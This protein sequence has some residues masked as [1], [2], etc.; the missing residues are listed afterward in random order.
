M[1]KETI[2]ITY[3]VYR[4]IAELPREEQEI[5]NQSVQVTKRVYAPYSHFQVGAA[6]LL[7]NGKIVAGG[8]IENSAYPMCLCAERVTLAAAE[9][10][11][12]GITPLCMGI[13]VIYTKNQPLLPIPPCGACRQ[14]LSETEGRYNHP[15]RL[16]LH[17]YSGVTY[18]FDNASDLL[19]FGF[20]PGV[21]TG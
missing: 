13:S 16:L 9:S 20:T 10:Q 8:N 3:S 14:V 7:S 19:P 1:K 6:L 5:I 4:T 11:Y 15:I 2:Q 21:L 12:P 18:A 17:G